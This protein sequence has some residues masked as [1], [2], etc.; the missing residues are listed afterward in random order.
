MSSTLK[1]D[2]DL[3]AVCVILIIW[4]IELTKNIMCVWISEM[5]TR[6]NFK[7]KFVLDYEIVYL[8]VYN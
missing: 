6:E 3:C 4:H 7:D 5:W 1:R 8:N 2:N